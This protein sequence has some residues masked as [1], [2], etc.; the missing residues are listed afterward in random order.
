MGDDAS[1][2][3]E[4]TVVPVSVGD[5]VQVTNPVGAFLGGEVVAVGE[6]VVWL[7]NVRL[8]V[9]ARQLLVADPSG[10]DGAFLR[11]ADGLPIR[12][13]D[14]VY[15]EDG[16]AWR[17]LRIVAGKRHCVQGSDGRVTRGLLPS[18]L[19]HAVPAGAMT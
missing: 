14:T 7:R 9:D 11:G 15:G 19:T 16:H 18:W 17:V 6:S 2:S 4:G 10:D 13:G 1:I 8:G 3:S 5:A 12:I